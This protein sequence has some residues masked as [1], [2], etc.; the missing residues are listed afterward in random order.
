MTFNPQDNTQVCVT[1]LGIFKLFRFV[2]N[3]LK[4]FAFQKADV[5]RHYLCQAWISEER[6]IVG[7]DVGKVSHYTTTLLFQIV[8]GG[9]YFLKIPTLY[10]VFFDKI[11]PNHTYLFGRKL[12]CI[13]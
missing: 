5:N 8:G 11:R 1:G 13:N 4:Q 3:N 9:G 10:Y 2:E 12:V 7:T 6:V